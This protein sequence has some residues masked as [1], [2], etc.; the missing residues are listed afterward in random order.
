[1]LE[2]VLVSLYT[3]TFVKV[4]I[5]NL[6]FDLFNFKFFFENLEHSI[7]ALHNIEY[8]RLFDKVTV[9]GGKRCVIYHILENTIEKF[10]L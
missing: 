1:M 8:L 6:D 10:N 4:L 2:A 3:I 5:R 7:D 9:L